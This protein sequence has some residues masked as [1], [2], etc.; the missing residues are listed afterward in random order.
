MRV[1]RTIEH[2]RDLVADTRNP[3][4]DVAKHALAIIS[5]IQECGIKGK[6]IE[7][8]N[9]ILEPLFEQG[10]ESLFENVR[11][12]APDCDI[13]AAI[14]ERLLDQSRMG[15]TELPASNTN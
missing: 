1:C 7:C 2:L 11:E 9:Y 14:N 13:C 8:L 5:D 4:G 15:I 6:D 3:L 10:S 12:G